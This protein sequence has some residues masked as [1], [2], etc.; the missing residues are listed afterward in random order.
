MSIGQ[1]KIAVAVLLIGFGVTS[2]AAQTRSASGETAS[3]PAAEKAATNTAPGMK[4]QLLAE[5]KA[6]GTRTWAVIF[7][8]G[9]DP[10]V[11]LGNFAAEHN[12]HAAQITGIGSLE[13]AE[14]EWLNHQTKKFKAMTITHQHEVLSFLGNISVYQNK[15]VV[16]VHVALGD[17]S[18]HAHG[19][20]LITAKVWPT[21]EVIV[22]EFPSAMVKRPAPE[23]GITVIDPSLGKPPAQ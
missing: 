1:R 11:G 18:G 21:L 7:A 13:S 10:M 23:L 3:Q 17:G 12:I 15:P 22:N 19:G 16:H 20:H 9:D 5:D 4:V 14:I 8:P 6:N 2:L